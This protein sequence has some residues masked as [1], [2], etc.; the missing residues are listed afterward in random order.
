MSDASDLTNRALGGDRRALARLLTLFE[1]QGAGTDEALARLYPQ[2][3]GAHV[4]GVTGAP[5]CG[6]S[7]LVNQIAL[8]T[9]RQGQTVGIVAVDPSSP[10][11]GGALLGDR[12]RM[13]DLAGDEGIFIRSMASRG[14]LGGLA[15]AT[16]DVVKVLDAAG[17]DVVLVET[18]GAGQS[19][20]DIAGSAHTTLVVQV[21]GMGDDIQAIKAGIMEIADIFVVNKADQPGADATVMLLQTMQRLGRDE[22]RTDRR[23]HGTRTLAAETPP[24]E[25]GRV[26]PIIQ[27]VSTSGEGIPELV[28]AVRSHW[29]YLNC[30]GLLRAREEARVA[31]EF[32]LL[33]R[34]RLLR[35]LL[36]RVAPGYLEQTVARVAA[37]EVDPYSAVRELIRAGCKE[38]PA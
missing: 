3:G 20:V 29:E 32:E 22:P 35:D 14:S 23:H 37:R 10:F 13:R 34:E 25:S 27:T 21:P 15:R 1:N 2:T 33:L 12:I 8:E 17:F 11:S 6:K 19:E 30:S 24:A 4:V 18:V 31:R 36:G 26:T 28:A 7:T 5:G 38:V 16:G 9:R